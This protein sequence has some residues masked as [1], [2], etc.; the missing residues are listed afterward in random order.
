MCKKGPNG[1]NGPKK[2][3]QILLAK[4]IQGTSLESQG[5][6]SDSSGSENNGSS[7]G[8]DSDLQ[9]ETSGKTQLRKKTIRGP[10]KK[11]SVKKAKK[12]V[13]FREGAD[14]VADAFSAGA[15]PVPKRVPT[16]YKF[17]F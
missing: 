2:A 7:S 9:L 6:I 17:S 11:N 5:R 12:Q 4:Q 13:G 15:A 16:A 1:P 3:S 8:G 14:S 10:S